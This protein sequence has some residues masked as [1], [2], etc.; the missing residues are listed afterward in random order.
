MYIHRAKK[1]SKKKKEDSSSLPQEGK[2]NEALP[3]VGTER[4]FQVGTSISDVFGTKSEDRTSEGT[5]FSLLSAFGRKES[6]DDD[7]DD[8]EDDAENESDDE[9]IALSLLDL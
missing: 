8:N 4:Y 2:G 1:K 5:G 3:E 9:G 7:D 6:D